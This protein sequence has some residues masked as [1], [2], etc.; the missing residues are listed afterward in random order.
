[1]PPSHLRRAHKLAQ[2]KTS[3]IPSETSPESIRFFKTVSPFRSALPASSART[4]LG[5]GSP[6]K[7]SGV[8]PSRPPIDPVW[9]E[10]TAANTSGCYLKVIHINVRYVRER[11][12]SRWRWMLAL[13]S[14]K[15]IWR[16]RCHHIIAEQKSGC[17]LN[18]LPL[19]WFVHIG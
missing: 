17:S 7:C 16:A 11:K 4:Q 18:H 5:H 2:Y 19:F 9:E 15:V 14:S 10:P 6:L 12:V 8:K 3:M 13:Q 1:M